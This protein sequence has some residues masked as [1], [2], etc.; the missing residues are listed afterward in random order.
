MNLIQCANGHYY[1]MD[2]YNICPFCSG[3]GTGDR[4]AYDMPT[5]GEPAGGFPG[6]YADGGVTIPEIIT[7]TDGGAGVT[8]PA[9]PYDAGGYVGEAPQES[10]REDDVVTTPLLN[11]KALEENEKRRNEGEVVSGDAARAEVANPVVGWLVCISGSNYGQAFTLHS[12]RNFIGRDTKQNDVA[13]VGD[14]SISRVKH[15]IVIYEP[16]Q[17]K[18][19]VQSGETAHEL[20][21]LNGEGVFANTVLKD[22]DE[23]TL[24]QT[25]LIFVSFCDG[26]I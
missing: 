14:V 24:G 10:P 12:G 15:A 22:R 21:Y 6:D 25:S 20:V 1:D 7:E 13:L 2:K 11:M 9:G 26:I 5:V 16:K 4:R 19:Y 3:S 17:R 23:I 18:F 8:E